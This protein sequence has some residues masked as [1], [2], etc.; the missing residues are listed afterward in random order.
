[1][2]YNTPYLHENFEQHR[3]E[4][5]ILGRFPYN[6]NECP[7]WIALIQDD[8]KKHESAYTDYMCIIYQNMVTEIKQFNRLVTVV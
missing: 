8:R 3:L 2:M 4:K 7:R 1:M 6:L 5:T